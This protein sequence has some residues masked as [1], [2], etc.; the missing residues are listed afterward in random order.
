MGLRENGVER[1]MR[2]NLKWER[3]KI[4]LTDNGETPR[5]KDLMLFFDDFGVWEGKFEKLRG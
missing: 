4:W 2:N 1:E 3:E 5:K